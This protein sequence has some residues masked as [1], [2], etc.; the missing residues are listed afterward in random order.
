MVAMLDEELMDRIVEG[1]P[2]SS[3]VNQYR[4]TEKD[5]LE[6]YSDE[7]S[8][9]ENAVGDDFRN[10]IRSTSIRIANIGQYGMA[11]SAANGRALE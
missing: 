2:I 4:T 9:E 5:S 1:Q 11:D 7:D 6:G 10:N 8:E 3:I